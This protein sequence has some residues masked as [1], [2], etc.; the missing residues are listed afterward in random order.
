VKKLPIVWG[1][2]FLF[3]FERGVTFFVF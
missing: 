1:S 3:G 2:L